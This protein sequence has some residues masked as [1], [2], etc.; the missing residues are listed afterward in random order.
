MRKILLTNDDGYTAE[1]IRILLEKLKPYG[2]VVLVA[3]HHHKSG[4][5]MSR[6]SWYD[7][8]I[9][10]H[11]A[12]IY[13]V[14]GTPADAVH[15]AL[16]GLKIQP[17]IIVSGIND[18]HNIGLDTLYSGTIG[19]AME[20][21]KGG[22]KAVAFSTDFGHFQAAADDFDNVMTFIL[23][24]DLLSTDYILNVN[25]VS[26]AYDCAKGIIVTDLAFRQ[27]DQYYVELGENLY[28][29]RRR[30]TPYEFI[31]GTDLWAAE[32]G[33]ISITPLKLGNQTQTGLEELKKKV[34]LHVE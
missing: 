17:D 31:E 25:F 18:G 12:N 10:F 33:Y 30:Y 28:K 27:T 19:A 9:H 34:G 22:Y 29:N 32:H 13:S 4:A 6:V 7:T 2:D 3:P 8:P 14:D 16:Y 15:F 11:E 5:A 26:K 20:G 23:E 24:K 1:G 21:L